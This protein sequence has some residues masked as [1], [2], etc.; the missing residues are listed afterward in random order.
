MIGPDAAYAA[1]ATVAAKSVAPIV[2]APFVDMAPPR[3]GNQTPCSSCRTGVRIGP[4]TRRSTVPARAPSSAQLRHRRG[5][6][7]EAAERVHELH[8]LDRPDIGLEQPREADEL[9]PAL[10]TRGGDLIRLRL[11]TKPRPR[12]AS[13]P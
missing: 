4:P 8:L 6:H 5:L 10:R 11:K 7:D 9:D 3:V 1:A 13:S 2:T 12:G